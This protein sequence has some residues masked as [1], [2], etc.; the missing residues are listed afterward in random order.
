VFD[1]RV[2]DLSHAA[3]AALGLKRPGIAPVRLEI[4]EGG[5]SR[6]SASTGDGVFQ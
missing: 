6:R 5:A 3:G 2:I 1:G 4:L